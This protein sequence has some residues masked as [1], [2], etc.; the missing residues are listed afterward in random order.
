MQAKGSQ[1]LFPRWSKSL[2]AH[3]RDPGLAA[4][5]GTKLGGDKRIVY[6]GREVG[7]WQ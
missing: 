2:R 6:L 7:I 3:G 5:R 4:G 1:A